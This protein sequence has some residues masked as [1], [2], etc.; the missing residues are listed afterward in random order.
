MKW[1][2]DFRRFL[3]DLD[4]YSIKRP[5]TPW[6][7]M[8]LFNLWATLFLGFMCSTAM[9]VFGES[10]WGI[11]LWTYIRN[12]LLCWP[13]LYLGGLGV[14]GI[15]RVTKRIQRHHGEIKRMTHKEKRAQGICPNCKYSLQGN[16]SA[17]RCPECGKYL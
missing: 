16:P 17:V 9:L 15:V 4:Y 5:P 10:S 11:D 1:I 3:R 14:I 2:E 8:L 6:S 7:G 12:A 13:F